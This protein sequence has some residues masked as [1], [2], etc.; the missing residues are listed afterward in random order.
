VN[1]ITRKQLKHDKFAEEVGQTFSFLTEHRTEV[2]R[3]GS[4]AAVVL[5]LIGGYLLYSRHEATVREAALQQAIRIDQAIV[6]NAPTATSLAFPTK[7][8]QEKARMKAFSDLMTDYHGTA[9]GAIGALYVAADEADKGNLAGAEKIYQDVIDSSPKDYGSLAQMA[10]ADLYF[11]EKKIT[12]AKTLL[13]A[14]I[15]HPTDLVSSE[16]AQLELAKIETASNPQEAMKLVTPL[17]TSRTAISKVAV[18]E[19]SQIHPASSK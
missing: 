3:Y 18:Q 2:I 7:E 16:E 17:E 11:G 12:E 10:L 1:R 14:L 5:V 19:A 6:G 4:I 9:E 15:D 13:Q 8:A